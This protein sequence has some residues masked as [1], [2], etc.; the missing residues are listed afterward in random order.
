M[1]ARIRAHANF[2]EYAP[3]FI[4]LL[5]LAE[6]Q[7]LPLYGVHGFGV[8]FIVGRLIHAWGLLTVEPGS[9]SL[10]PRVAGMAM[11]FLC[12]GGLAMT[13]IYQFLAFAA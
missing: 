4:L 12:L 3:L 9:Q 6:S 10:L 1:Q 7:G 5:A 8:L 2:A 13:L 11:T